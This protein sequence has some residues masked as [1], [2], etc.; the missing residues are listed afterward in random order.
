MDLNDLRMQINE[1]DE[2]ILDLFVRRMNVCYDVAEYKIK[3]DLPVFHADREQQIIDR[4]RKE[5]SDDMANSAE[6]LFTNIMDISKCKQFQRFFANESEIAYIPLDLTG[7]HKVAVPGTI[8]SY[9]HVAAKH[10]LPESSPVFYELFAEVFEAVANGNADFGVVPI[11]NS[12]AGTVS[13]T[14]ELMNKYDFKICASN[15]VAANHCF[16]VKHGT[17]ISRI[18]EVYSHEQA[19]AQ[20]S[21]Y[22]ESHGYK[23]HTYENTALA[24]CFVSESSNPIAAICSEECAN[25]FGLDIIDYGIA[26]AESNFTKFILISKEMR[27]A[28]GAD[29]ISVVLSVPHQRS[30]LYRMLTKF[31]VSGLNLTKIESRPIANTDFDVLFYLDFEGSIKSPDVVK[32]IRELET[33]LSYFKFLGNYKEL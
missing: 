9:S 20:C 15:K 2:Q 19:L 7:S 32:L 31:S 29:I 18:K 24:A 5:V 14:Y 1:I 27:L 26:N 23:T 11:V 16:V 28:E 4:V 25:H 17:D 12:T 22:I 13:Q 33:E 6:V 10:F 30:S 3:N 8:G 21:N